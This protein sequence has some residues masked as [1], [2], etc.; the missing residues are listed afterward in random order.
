MWPNQTMQMFLMKTNAETRLIYYY[1]TANR[2]DFAKDFGWKNCYVEKRFGT[3]K[4]VERKKFCW[5]NLLVKK[6]GVDKNLFV[7]KFA[8]QK[9]I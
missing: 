7:K 4:W 6:I 1:V 5:K 2:V 9:T 3:K 8:G